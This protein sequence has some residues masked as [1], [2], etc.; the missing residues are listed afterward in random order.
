MKRGINFKMSN[1]LFRVSLA[2]LCSR[3][4]T[5]LTSKRPPPRQP[6]LPGY[7]QYFLGGKCILI[8]DTTRR[9]ECGSNP[10][11]SLR[12]PT[13]YHKATVPP[14]AAYKCVGFKHKHIFV[15]FVQRSWATNSDNG[16][17]LYYYIA[18]QVL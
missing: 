9:P 18:L 6:R 7:Y 4:S 15:C 5:Q 13:F 3:I 12:S 2:V 14:K 11:L 17:C 16:V 10:N 1:T 8:K